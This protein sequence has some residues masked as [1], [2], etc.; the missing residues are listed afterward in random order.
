M[1]EPEETLR[2]VLAFLGEGYETA[3]LDFQRTARQAGGGPD[4]HV[5]PQS[6]LSSARIGRW[7][8][9]LTLFERKLAEQIAGLLLSELEYERDDTPPLTG[10]D[11]AQL[12]V[13]AVKFRAVD[14]ARSLLYRY[15]GRS[16][17]VNR[18]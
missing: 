15:G 8:G 5:E 1:T 12:A 13:L 7:R 6:A 14:G 11:R 4:G 3:V 10:A 17:N 9:E 2:G 18:R 16:L